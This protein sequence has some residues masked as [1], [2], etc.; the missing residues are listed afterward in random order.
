MVVMTWEYW[1]GSVGADSVGAALLKPARRLEQQKKERSRQIYISLS[2][3]HHK[4][5]AVRLLGDSSCPLLFPL[6]AEQSGLPGV[7]T[8][9]RVFLNML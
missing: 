5:C 2:F 6:R 7:S 1:R 3:A 9:Q 8:G 4:D